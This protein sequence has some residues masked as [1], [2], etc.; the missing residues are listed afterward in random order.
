MK[1]QRFQLCLLAALLTMMVLT[2]CK[3]EEKMVTDNRTEEAYDIEQ[4]FQPFIDFLAE[5][6]K[7]LSILKSYSSS[8]RI[9]PKTLEQGIKYS[10]N[11]GNKDSHSWTF[12]RDFP[13]G[14]K[15]EYD[16][17]IDNQDFALPGRVE[18][19]LPTA[20]FFPTIPQDVFTSSD[21]VDVSS[22]NSE[23]YSKMISYET[24]GNQKLKQ[25]LEKEYQL[26]SLDITELTLTVTSEDVF[27]MVIS[28]SDDSNTYQVSLN[29]EIIN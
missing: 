9:I 17:T 14:W 8:V 22:G 29:L 16:V 15:E 26:E 2:G 5:E 1:K 23:P 27:D 7:D 18:Y 10:L 6:E 24:E 21:V 3:K 28:M 12:N 11:F 4:V 20:S 19:R 25:L 13:S